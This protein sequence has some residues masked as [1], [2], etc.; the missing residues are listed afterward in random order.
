MVHETY[1]RRLP[2]AVTSC[3]LL[4]SMH[5]PPPPLHLISIYSLSPDQCFFFLPCT[6]RRI[7]KMFSLV[8]TRP[9]TKPLSLIFIDCVPLSRAHNIS[10]PSPYID[11]FFG[12]FFT[13]DF[14]LFP[15][16]SF[17]WGKRGTGAHK[18][19]SLSPPHCQE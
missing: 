2:K 10:H 1:P 6:V 15:P 5:A 3:R 9:P 14:F 12:H 13:K 19:R 18:S 17:V 11:G 16:P 4:P 7:A 8:P